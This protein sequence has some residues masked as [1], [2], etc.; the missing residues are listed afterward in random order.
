MLR[1][2]S[3][4]PS[5]LRLSRSRTLL[6]G[7]RLWEATNTKLWPQQRFRASLTVL[8][9]GFPKCRPDLGRQERNPTLGNS[10]PEF[11]ASTYVR[12]CNTNP[13]GRVWGRSPTLMTI[14]SYLG[15]ERHTDTGSDPCW[16]QGISIN[17]SFTMFFHFLKDHSENT[18]W[19]FI[20]SK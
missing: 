19:C 15:P 18:L 1:L 12:A 20:V 4:A 11:L 6:S 17:G 3:S 9:A 7:T 2:Q 8:R 10:K 16:G 14:S 5:S 13:Q